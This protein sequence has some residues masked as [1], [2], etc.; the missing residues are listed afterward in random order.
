M[1]IPIFF[2]C[3]TFAELPSR[4]K[5]TALSPDKLKALADAM[6][7]RDVEMN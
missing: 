7:G 6:T 1:M 4:S 5:A 2:V 3:A